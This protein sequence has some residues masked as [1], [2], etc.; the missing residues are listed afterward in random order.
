MPITGVSGT[1]HVY[2]TLSM[3]VKRAA[4]QYYIEKLFSGLLPK[5]ARRLIRRGR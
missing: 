4:D 5:I 1:I 2:P 3:G